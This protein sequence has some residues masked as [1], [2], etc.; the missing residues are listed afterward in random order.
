MR[1]RNIKP[2]YFKN[3]VLGNADPIYGHIYQGLWCLAD[4]EGRLE[5]RP[6]RIHIEINPYRPGASTMQA[7]DWLVSRG[8]IVRYEVGAE[9]YI[10]IPNFAAHQHPHVKES[11]SKIPPAPKKHQNG[12][13]QAPDKTGANPSDSGFLIPDSPLLIPDSGLLDAAPGGQNQDDQKIVPEKEK[14]KKRS[15]R[16][17]FNETRLRLLAQ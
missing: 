12:T 11:K 6:E 9:K 16:E 5:D 8:F 15:L 10:E 4:R 17:E 3:E 7:L 14:T 1:A 2:G 13:G